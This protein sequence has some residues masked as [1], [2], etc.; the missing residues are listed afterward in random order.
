M[1][2]LIG[3]GSDIK[4]A[5]PSSFSTSCLAHLAHSVPIALSGVSA[6]LVEIWGSQVT[7]S[8]VP[9]CGVILTVCSTDSIAKPICDRK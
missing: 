4:G 2:E 3:G 6:R 7:I 1:V 9:K 5:F 8:E